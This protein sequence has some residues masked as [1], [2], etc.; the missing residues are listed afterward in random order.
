LL[1]SHVLR[2]WQG[3]PQALADRYLI[4]FSHHVL[5]DY[6]VGRV[7]LRGGPDVLLN[8]LLSDREFVVFARPS[9]AFHFQHLWTQDAPGSQ[10][11]RF[12]QVV[13]SV[14]AQAAVSE[15]AKLVGPGTAVE[16]ATSVAELHPLVRALTEEAQP[17]RE[18]AE[19]SFGY[20][21]GALM[22]EKQARGRIPTG[23]WPALLELVSRSFSRQSAYP[24]R[25]LLLELCGE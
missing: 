20:L 12:W 17:D 13:F 21:V 10:H 15:V 5:F 8:R 9:L 22:T 4:G 23:P 3:D 14:Q 19:G 16:F 11:E 18:R 25:A 24:A 1:S 2:E 7:L 6:A